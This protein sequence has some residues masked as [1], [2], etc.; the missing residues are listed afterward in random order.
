MARQESRG[1]DELLL[2]GGRVAAQIQRTAHV[3]PRHCAEALHA[4]QFRRRRTALEEI[5]ASFDRFFKLPVVARILVEAK[6][7]AW[8][9][10]HQQHSLLAE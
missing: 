6:D 8:L 4:V 7:E 3:H 2:P 10:L 9:A 5:K 1:F